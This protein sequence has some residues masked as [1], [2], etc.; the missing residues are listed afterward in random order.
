[1]IG[2]ARKARPVDHRYECFQLGEFG[3]TH[4]ALISTQPA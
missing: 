3:S 4:Y 2:G 1:M